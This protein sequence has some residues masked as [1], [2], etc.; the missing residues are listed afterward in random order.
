[1]SRSIFYIDTYY[2]NFLAAAG[3]NTLAEPGESYASLLEQARALGFGTGFAYCSAFSELGWDAH[4]AIPNSLRLQSAWR[5]EHGKRAPIRA[6]WNYPLHLAR[7]PIA[8]SLLHRFPQVHGVLLDQ[9]KAVKPD[10][11]VVQ[12]LNLVPLAL[13]NELN[14]HTGLLVGEIASPLPPRHYFVGYD[15]I[16]SALPP[17]VDQARAWGIPAE[18]VPLGFD[19][20]W[21]AAP[22][23]RERDIDAVF[24]GSF[25]RHQPQTVPMLQSVA[26]AVPGLRIYGPASGDMLAEAGL[27]RHYVGEAWGADMFDVLSRSKIVVNRHGTVSGDFA[28]N[29]RMYEATGSGAALVTEAKSNLEQLFEPGVEV[30]TYRD[31]TDLGPTVAALLADPARLNRIAT[32]GFERT[33]RDHSYL[34]R[35]TQLNA[36]FTPELTV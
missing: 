15:L 5:G 26:A 34:A 1:M 25:S 23:S 10:V 27:E 22:D 36:L 18:Y 9:V 16:V 3:L 28:V 4:I 14:K 6:G 21:A 2:P 7:L 32:A 19:P 13:A 30:E 12:D 31:F 17:I 29:M 35:A 20:R 33:I 8:R 24:V 11:I